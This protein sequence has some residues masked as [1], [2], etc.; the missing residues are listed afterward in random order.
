MIPSDDELISLSLFSDDT[1]NAI[2]S[3]KN[4]KRYTGMFKAEIVLEYLKGERGLEELA[5]KY[6]VHPNQIKNW[7][8]LLFKRAHEVL[9]DKRSQKSNIHKGDN[10]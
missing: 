4:R 9:G 2:G 6:Q 8:A 7:K 5:Q 10:R 1:T 3:K